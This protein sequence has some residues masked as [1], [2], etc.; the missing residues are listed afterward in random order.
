MPGT[1]LVTGVTHYLAVVDPR[2]VIIPPSADAYGEVHPTGVEFSAIQDGL[3]NTVS[4]V[5]AGEQSGVV[6]TSSEDLQL[7][8]ESSD[9]LGQL[10]G[11]GFW[12]L[13]CDGKSRFVPASFDSANLKYLFTRGDGNRISLWSD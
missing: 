7:C 13:C 1:D 3:Q 12:A 8:H 9:G 10:R 2:F 6:W 5:E 11:N 4:I